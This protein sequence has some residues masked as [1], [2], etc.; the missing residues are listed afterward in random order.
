MPPMGFEPTILAGERAVDL[1]LRP[2][3][4]RDRNYCLIRLLKSNY[5][6][7]QDAS[8]LLSQ[9]FLWIVMILRSG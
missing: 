7:P 1:R 2:R 6:L 8:R 3:G 4:R 5:L 9:R